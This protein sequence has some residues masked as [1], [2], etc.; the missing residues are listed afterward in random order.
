MEKVSLSLPAEGGLG[1][2]GLGV[3]PG[4]S[5]AGWDT[6]VSYQC[7]AP[8]PDGSFLPVLAPGGTGDA[9][10]MEDLD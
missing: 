2:W 6:C 9:S 1:R 5:G 7:P 4:S 8:A 3:G 10:P